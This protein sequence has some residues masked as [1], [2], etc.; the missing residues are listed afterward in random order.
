MP[1]WA[2]V[3]LGLGLIL[4]DLFVFGA[5]S[6]VL[7]VFAAGAFAA[8]VAS[9]L[10]LDATAQ[11]M[12]AVA[13]SVISVPVAL[14]ASRKLRA[15]PSGVLDEKR[16]DQREFQVTRRK[17]TL[18][19]RVLG[20]FFPVRRVDGGTVREGDSVWLLRFE[21]ITALVESASEQS[22]ARANNHKGDIS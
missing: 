16:M 13:G 14:F 19:I 11:I 12:F 10:G 1:A 6:I 17:D 5:T 18:G 22:T 21:G 2:L 20:D 9:G 3:V 8:A 15:A 7:L 4:L